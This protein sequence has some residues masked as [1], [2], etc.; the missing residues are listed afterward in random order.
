M[1]A[2]FFQLGDDLRTGD[3]IGVPVKP[4]EIVGDKKVR[5]FL[6]DKGIH[7]QPQFLFFFAQLAIAKVLLDKP[8]D[9]EDGAHCPGFSRAYFLEASVA[10]CVEGSFFSSGKQNQRHCTS[11]RRE[12]MQRSP[13]SDGF[14]SGMR[15][16]NKHMAKLSR[17]SHRNR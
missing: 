12:M 17:V 7:E 2:G 8:G 16:Y 4:G 15:E 11:S 9:T 6:F 3:M 1:K 14:I 5:F 10:C 13:A